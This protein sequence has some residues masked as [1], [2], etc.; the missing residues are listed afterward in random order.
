M[1]TETRLRATTRPPPT[2]P[3]D[4]G[5]INQR[6]EEIRARST[7]QRWRGAPLA[8]SPGVRADA[9]GE[10]SAVLRTCLLA[11]RRSAVERDEPSEIGRERLQGGAV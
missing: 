3:R 5:A 10:R 6:R 9:F 7:P 11:G 8:L 4:C 1:H 2:Q